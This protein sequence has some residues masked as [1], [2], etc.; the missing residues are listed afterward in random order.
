MRK[1]KIS[2]P[3]MSLKMV[4]LWLQLHLSGA[5]DLTRSCDNWVHVYAIWDIRNCLWINGLSCVFY[6]VPIYEVWPIRHH[7]WKNGMRC[8][9]YNVPIL[10]YKKCRLVWIDSRSCVNYLA[11]GK[12]DSNFNN[13]IFKL[14]LCINILSN[15]CGITLMWMLKKTFDDMST[16]VQI[17]AW[18]HQATNHNRWQCW[19]TFMLPYEVTRPQWVKL[20]RYPICDPHR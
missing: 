13:V 20:K 18:C 1:M 17:M 15:S 4:N 16:L 11:P 5:N 7:S 14:N 9:L 3:V 8:V 12:C 2:S 10:L 19:P 6:N